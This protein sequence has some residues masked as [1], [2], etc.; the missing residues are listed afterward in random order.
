MKKIQF[1][2]L[3]LFLFGIIRLSS[4]QFV[5]DVHKLE[6]NLRNARAKIFAQL[7]NRKKHPQIIDIR[8]PEEYASGHI[9]NAVLINYYDRNFADN[10]EK[11]GFDKLGVI[12]IYCRSGQRSANSIPIFKKLGFKHIIN[13]NYGINEWNR[14][15][16]PLET[17]M[18]AM[19]N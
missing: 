11:A 13:L 14:L 5:S 16:L 18:P 1:N 8:T 6:P 19:N 7:I 10:I 17:G 4:G 15:G 9:K 3:I 12:F 2:F